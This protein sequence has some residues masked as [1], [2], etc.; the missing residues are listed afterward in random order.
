MGKFLNR[1]IKSAAG[2]GHKHR[3]KR[4]SKRNK[5]THSSSTLKVKSTNR[6]TMNA[7]QRVQQKQSARTIHHAEKRSFAQQRDSQRRR[8]LAKKRRPKSLEHLKARKFGDAR[9]VKG[10]KSKLSILEVAYYRQQESN[11]ESETFRDSYFA[12][13][14]NKMSTIN[15]SME[16]NALI[17]KIGPFCASLPHVLLHKKQIFDGIIE[18]INNE[19][20]QH[21][22]HDAVGLLLELAKDIKHEFLPFVDELMLFLSQMLEWH[23]ANLRNM[24]TVFSAF[25]WLFKYLQKYMEMRDL[26]KYYKTY[27]MRFLANNKYYTRDFMAQIFATIFR[28]KVMLHYQPP[29]DQASADQLHVFNDNDKI[30][31]LRNDILSI[32]MRDYLYDTKQLNDSKSTR[33]NLQIGLSVFL[34]QIVRGVLKAFHSK[35]VEML[36]LMLKVLHRQRVHVDADGAVPDEGLMNREN[37]EVQ[38]QMKIFEEFVDLAAVYTN[39]KHCLAFFAPFYAVINKHLAFMQKRANLRQHSDRTPSSSSTTR[40]RKSV[41]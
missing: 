23:D 7:L 22:L 1:L 40:D 38:H 21:I 5:K 18:F 37:E 12:A 26:Q 29:P 17:N 3:K 14:I 33:K 20:H 11:E 10:F 19:A 2:S 24:Q 28:S 27:F 8:D 32:N 15:R 25:S 41:V 16:M 6:G 30:L 36:P 31:L 35:T 9:Q 4:D 34:F 39:N 13:Y